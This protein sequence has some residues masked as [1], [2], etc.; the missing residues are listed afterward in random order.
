MR[1]CN[2]THIL[3]LLSASCV[4]KQRDR[5]ASCSCTGDSLTAPMPS[6]PCWA[7]L[8]GTPYKTNPFFLMSLLSVRFFTAT[9]KQLIHSQR[10]SGYAKFRIQVAKGVSDPDVG[11]FYPHSALP[12]H[13]SPVRSCPGAPWG[14]CRDHTFHLPLASEAHRP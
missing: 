9:E 6:S 5:P 1:V 4:R 11:V 2:L 10:F 14:G 13:I 3:I 12:F 8:L 7:L